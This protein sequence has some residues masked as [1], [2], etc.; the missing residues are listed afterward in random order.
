MKKF[1]ILLFTFLS[2]Y[3]NSF[4]C[5]G[6]SVAVTNVTYDGST[7][8][9]TAEV[10]IG[11]SPNW[12]A[13]SSFVLDADVAITGLVTSS[14]TSTY[15]YCSVSLVFN[16]QGCA[17][18]AMG[19]APAG[20]TVQTA[21]VSVSG[22]IGGG[23]GSG[24]VQ[25]SGSGGLPL[26]P[27]DL[28]ADCAD[29]GNGNSL[30]WDITFETTS[31]LSSLQL[32]DAEG[33]GTQCPDEIDTSIPA[34]P[35]ACSLPTLAAPTI[36][37]STICEGSTVTLGAS[38]TSNC[39]GGSYTWSGPDGFSGS[40]SSDTDS[41]TSSG[42]YTVSYGSGSC[43]TSAT[44]GV[45][46]NE[47]PTA[48]LNTAAIGGCTSADVPVSFTGTGPY[49]FSYQIG[50]SGW[51]EVVGT[52]DNP[53]LIP[54]STNS[55]VELANGSGPDPDGITST[56]CPGTPGPT[57]GTTAVTVSTVSS[58][59]GTAWTVLASVDEPLDGTGTS[60]LDGYDTT[61]TLM[62]DAGSVTDG[63][64]EDNDAG[65]GAT[66]T[67]DL[68]D[69]GLTCSTMDI[70]S[71]PANS[72]GFTFSGGAGSNLVA[73]LC[74]G[75]SC[76]TV[77]QGG[78]GG[79]PY[80]FS[81]G[82][83]LTLINGASCGSGTFDLTITD[84]RT[85]GGPHDDGSTLTGFTVDLYDFTATLVTN[86]TYLWTASSGTAN[87]SFL[88]CTTCEDPTFNT[89]TTGAGCYDL[90]VTDGFGCTDVS[91]VCYDVVLGL[92]LNYFNAKVIE[93]NK[94]ELEWETFD[95]SK[96]FEVQRSSD[97]YNF[98]TIGTV[99]NTEGANIFT[100]IDSAPLNTSY[101]RLKTFDE[102]DKFDYSSTKQV[103]LKS[104]NELAIQ[105]AYPIPANTNL[106]VDIYS[107]KNKIV[108]YK[109]I[110]MTGRELINENME[111]HQGSSTINMDIEKLN[112]GNFVFI[113][114]DGSK[115]LNAKVVKK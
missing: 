2:I 14:F 98:I 3:S 110:D 41:P 93:S 47:L 82:D 7:Y 28:D 115:Q 91:T 88:S 1:T 80:Y 8:F 51:V 101:Y 99:N 89:A 45:T 79:S 11:L 62:S 27:D 105:Q 53:Y 17:V 25:F 22:S 42:S 46:V 60:G 109:L 21:N 44:V 85:G 54:V 81:T 24:N 108:N 58:D 114:T 92:K 18:T 106:K 13:T 39:G 68:S 48:A 19:S 29:C 113:I 65:A 112:S 59:A 23:A 26:G 71:I 96:K 67:Y 87:T 94:V 4:A 38:C 55:T 84:E 78:V 72:I 9:Y 33:S 15:D 32:L 95:Y 40:G 16:G 31:E 64:I 75:G 107:G 97:G 12:G 61:T 111:L 90:T 52:T 20:G 63:T 103:E 34:A 86:P 50:G 73:E 69:L 37:S 57:S 74:Y 102:N 43:V 104:S 66:A 100:H 30:C 76:I 36:S 6:T 49:T 56:T 83:I 77:P 70:N 10:C 5:D 35:P